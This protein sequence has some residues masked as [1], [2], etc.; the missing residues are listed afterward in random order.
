[1]RGPS[2][3]AVQGVNIL[4]RVLLGIP[5]WSAD[6]ERMVLPCTGKPSGPVRADAELY[7][8]VKRASDSFLG[9]PSQCFVTRKA[10]IGVPAPRGRPQYCSNIAMKVG[11]GVQG[12]G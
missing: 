6:F 2:R 5:L 7:K 9:V 4:I 3:G 11:L 8:E 10:S 1:M 12:V